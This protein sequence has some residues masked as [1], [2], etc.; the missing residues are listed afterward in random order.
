MRPTRVEDAE[1]VAALQPLAF[2]PPFDPGYHWRARHIAAHVRHFPAGQFVAATD[3]GR[4]VASSSNVP[5]TERAW[6]AHRERGEHPY[7]VDFSGLTGEETTLYGADIA[8]HP[9]FRRQGIARAIYA[10]RF[11][12]VRAHPF[13]RYGTATRMPD[14]S[15]QAGG[16]DPDAYARRVV[17][18]RLNDRTLTP[19]L[20]MGLTFLNTVP[21]SWPDPESGGASAILQ[22]R[23]GER[24]P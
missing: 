13:A 18:G 5:I 6:T 15:A 10:A 24:V 1:A 20:K 12:L 21:A 14:L 19:L 3:D 23:L 4:I 8:V 17:E 11:A 9:D 7:R 22:W 2:P 16:L